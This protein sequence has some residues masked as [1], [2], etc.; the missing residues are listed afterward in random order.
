MDKIQRGAAI[1]I[2]DWMQL[3][4]GDTLLIVIDRCHEREERA[5]REAAEGD[6]I[7]VKTIFADNPEFTVGVYFD[8]HA[9]AFD[10]FWHIIGAT[11]YSLVTT[12]AAKRAIRRGGHFL[13]LPLSTNDG[14]SM[15]EYDFLMMDV[16]KSKVMAEVLMHTMR[17][18]DHIRAVTKAGTELYFR[19]HRRR[20]G[21]FNG[22]VRDGKG[23]SS[24]SFE[25][26]VPIEEDRT[27]GIGVLDGSYGYIGPVREPFRLQFEKG[28]ITRIEDSESGRKLSR[29]LDGFH[30]PNMRAAGEFGIGINSFSR[31]LGNC[32]IEDESAYGT[33]H[34]GLGRNLAL[35]G[36]QKAT[37]HFDIVFKEPTLFVDNRMIMQDGRITLDDPGIY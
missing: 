4:S 2:R 3:Q 35:G 33:F 10:G 27:E 21:F 22:D 20:A 9:G 26:Y 31:C 15:L 13:S 28:R 37:G 32:Y 24:S 17:D 25:V 34:I 8:E 19:K 14:R 11:T 18:S 12:L 6:G 7:H 5:L 1:V 30:D 36:R 29:Y 16:K 23:Y